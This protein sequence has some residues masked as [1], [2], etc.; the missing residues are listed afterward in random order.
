MDNQSNGEQSSTGK[1][2]SGKCCC[3]NNHCRTGR[4]SNKKPGLPK[5]RKKPTFV[6]FNNDKFK[7]VIADEAG[8]D[9]I[10]T[11]LQHLEKAAVQYASTNMIA[12]TSQAM[13]FL[14]PY[15]FRKHMPR[16][17]SEEQDTTDVQTDG[18]VTGITTDQGQKNVPEGI[19]T[20][21]INDYHKMR[22][23]Y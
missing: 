3:S 5:T 17:V 20:S 19:I 11:Q 21:D 22:S 18:K 23:K 9:S 16:P 4:T 15:D 6:G 2:Q 14:M 10:C 7:A 13:E 1:A 12:Y 8:L